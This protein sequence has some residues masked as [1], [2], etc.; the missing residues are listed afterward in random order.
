MAWKDDEDLQLG[1]LH[2]AVGIRDTMTLHALV[3]RWENLRKSAD[4][5]TCTYKVCP[6][7]VRIDASELDTVFAYRMFKDAGQCAV[8]M[9][10]MELRG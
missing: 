3:S 6:D 9:I 8:M 7:L 4:G 2:L 10:P 5:S 1:Q